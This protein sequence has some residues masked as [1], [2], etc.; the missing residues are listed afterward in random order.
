MIDATAIAERDLL[1]A[2]HEVLMRDYERR[3]GK[4]EPLPIIARHAPGKDAFRQYN[5]VMHLKDKA[6]PKAKT[7]APRKARARRKP[8]TK[9][10]LHQ[11]L[12]FKPRGTP[13]ARQNAVV[14]EVWA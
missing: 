8:A 3:N 1:R 5:Q 13:Q 4:V 2:E 7:P 11:H 14:R 6:A 10:A 12:P 9:Q